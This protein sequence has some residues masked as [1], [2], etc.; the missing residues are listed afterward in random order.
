MAHL[1]LFIAIALLVLHYNCLEL[2]NEISQLQ[3]IFMKSVAMLKRQE[4]CG[5]C[6]ICS[7]REELF[8]AMMNAS[9][10]LESLNYH[11]LDC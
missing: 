3:G 5:L 6:Q 7:K 8:N 4:D 2:F 1:R 10:Q 11:P 9:I